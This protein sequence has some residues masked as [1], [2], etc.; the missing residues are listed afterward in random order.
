M[1]R[2]NKNMAVYVEEE[3]LPSMQQQD[4]AQRGMW[5][6][7]EGGTNAR[8]FGNYFVSHLPFFCICFINLAEPKTTT[9]E[10]LHF[11]TLWL[12]RGLGGGGGRGE[13][14]IL[15]MKAHHRHPPFAG[16]R[17]KM[18]ANRWEEKRCEGKTGTEMHS[19]GREKQTEN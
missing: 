7:W 10:K 4:W 5:G 3:L 9:N 16:F 15:K 8:S 18:L 12:T 17:S 2:E 1:Q 13:A 11:F 14:S 19:S 6:G